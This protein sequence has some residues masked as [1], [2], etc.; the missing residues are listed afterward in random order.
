MSR[1]SREIFRRLTSGRGS[2]VRMLWSRSASLMRTTRRSSAIA[3]IILRMFSACCCWSV[4]MEMAQLGHTLD[5]SGDL[6][7]ELG[8][9]LVGG[10]RGVLHGIVEQGGGERLRVQ[11]Q[12]G[13]DRRYLKRV[14]DVVLARQPPLAPVGDGRAVVRLPDELAVLRLEMVGDAEQLGNGHCDRV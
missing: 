11:L 2:S 7:P 1:V 12:V 3:T 10:E 14:V 6:G 4:R 13:E 5:Q 8:L 9:D